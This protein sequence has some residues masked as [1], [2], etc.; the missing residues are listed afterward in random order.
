MV[1]FLLEANTVVLKPP[2]RSIIKGVEWFLPHF[3]WK[4]NNGESVSF[5][6]GL[7]NAKSPLS[8]YATR[9]F[10]ISNLKQGNVYDI[11]NQT[12]AD[13]DIKLRRPLYNFEEY[14]WNEIKQELLAPNH[15]RDNDLSIWKLNSNGQFDIASIKKEALQAD[16]SNTS[17][18]NSV[19]FKN[20]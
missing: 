2:W 1:I 19:I 8:A 12:Q 20:L 14:M 17:G 11:W 18:T 6:N 10:A 13:W 4:I 7:W 3:S 15:S 16:T 5:W 9:L